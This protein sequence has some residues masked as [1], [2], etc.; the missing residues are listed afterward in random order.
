[1][2]DR[3]GLG[4]R[5]AARLPGWMGSIRFRLTAL[6]SFVLF[7]LAAAVVAGI[8][9]GLA[10]SL[11]DEP[12]SRTYTV[13]RLFPSPT[14]GLVIEESVIRSELTQVEALV[15]E[16]T[17]ENLRTYSFLALGLLFVAS[18][19]VG[20][21]IAGRVLRPIGR[22]TEVAR[23]IQ[24]TDLSRRIALRGPDDELH[25]LADTFDGMLDRL[26][27]AFEG[28]RRFIHE[29]SHELRNP[30]AVMRTNLDVALSDPDSS[31]DDLRHTGEI[32]GRSAERMSRLVDDLLTWARQENLP[33]PR[34][35]ADVASVVEAV[36]QEFEA[37]ADAAGVQLTH[38]AV[39]GLWV[40]G[41]PRA[42]ERAAANLVANA[43][44]AAPPGSE[45]HVSAGQHD[46]WISLS[47]S[48]QGPGV[49]PELQ[50]R[51]FQRFWRGDE[52]EAR[53]EG[54]SGLGLAI[55]RQIAES[56]GGEVRLSSAPG[57]GATFTMW[58]PKVRAEDPT[59]PLR[60][61]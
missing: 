58:F 45:V 16:R 9:T 46:H 24:A 33:M 29:A 28:Q 53:R 12:V 51:V 7:G 50:E 6:Y 22:I 35:P 17:L 57:Q 8:Y 14:G 49:P 41:D 48:D 21:V 55:V 25:E 30:L 23:E 3:S 47:V 56:H 13:A 40:V 39:P 31:V 52:A 43:I 60:L 42:L 26:H 32:V 36:A 15:N 10:R 5:I 54:R 4:R 59:L 38:S 44:R 27:T 1:M 11:D 61:E 37:I 20:W 18:L 19:L 34:D 2:S